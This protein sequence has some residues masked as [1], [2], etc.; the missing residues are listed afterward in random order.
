MLQLSHTKVKA[1]TIDKERF[2]FAIINF[3]KHWREAI[4]VA[5]A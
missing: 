1:A 5:I 2:D 3:A 4:G